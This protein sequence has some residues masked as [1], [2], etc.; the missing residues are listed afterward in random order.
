ME[1][2]NCD[3]RDFDSVNWALR[4]MCRVGLANIVEMELELK[5]ITQY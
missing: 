5:Y 3:H 1:N 4:Y 2:T